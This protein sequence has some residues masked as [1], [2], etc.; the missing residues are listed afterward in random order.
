MQF[1]EASGN[2]TNSYNLLSIV[3]L[4]N[5]EE[6]QDINAINTF[7]LYRPEGLK[8]HQL[9][10]NLSAQNCERCSHILMMETRQKAFLLITGQLWYPVHNALFGDFQKP[11]EALAVCTGF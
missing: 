6:G 3:S 5:L 8:D 10:T 1:F 9:H 11:D 2:S 4:N 7:H